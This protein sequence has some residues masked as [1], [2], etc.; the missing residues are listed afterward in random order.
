MNNPPPRLRDVVVEMELESL[1]R[2]VLRLRRAH[3]ADLK[4]INLTVAA[5]ERLRQELHEAQKG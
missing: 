3:Q 1:R 2:E 5:N 4:L